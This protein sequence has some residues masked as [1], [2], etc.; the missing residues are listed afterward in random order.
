MRS[1]ILVTTL[2]FVISPAA[3]FAQRADTATNQARIQNA[4]SAAPQSLGANATVMDFE[5]NVLRR[6][7]NGWVCFP[8]MPDVPNDTPM[9][10]DDQWTG[11]L[12]AYMNRRQP[13]VTRLGIGYMLQADMPVSN[14]D[15][16][17][18]G[19]TADNQ[20]IP[21]AG[22]HIMLIVPDAKLLE[23]IPTDPNNGGPWVMWKGTPYEH[24]MIPTPGRTP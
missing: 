5:Q 21:N 3:A 22:P 24:L 2:L 19:P 9:C 13:D 18:T 7:T 1:L 6:G 16:F 23:G 4:L 10:V 17:A 15:P 8:D 12:D 14:V 20:W 11:F